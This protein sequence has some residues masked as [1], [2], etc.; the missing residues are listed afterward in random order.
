MLYIL[1][2][3]IYIV[4]IYYKYIY[5]YTLLMYTYMLKGFSGGSVVKNLPVVQ[6]MQE[7]WVRSLGGEDP[8]EVGMAT[9][10]SILAWKT[11]WSEEPGG[12]WSMGSQ[13]VGHD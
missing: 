5:I 10:S 2:I 6:E 7:M 11:P 3:H 13:R 8:L 9:H 4:Y 12:L 1:Y